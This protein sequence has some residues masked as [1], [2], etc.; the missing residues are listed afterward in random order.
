MSGAGGSSTA[1]PSTYSLINL[2]RQEAKP[3]NKEP[4]A[5]D[6]YGSPWKFF[7]LDTGRMTP[8]D[9]LFKGKFFAP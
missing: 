3:L 2:R 9:L 1:S 8:A 7:R 4:I 5:F 6:S